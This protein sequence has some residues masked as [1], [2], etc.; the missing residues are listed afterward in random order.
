MRMT[1]PKRSEHLTQIGFTTIKNAKSPLED[2]MGRSVNSNEYQ[3]PNKLLLEAAERYFWEHVVEEVMPKDTLSAHKEGVVYVINSLKA[4]SCPTV[5]E[6][7]S[8][9]Y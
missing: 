6:M 9:E 2:M 8:L 1:V 5:T 7:T 3:G 4:F